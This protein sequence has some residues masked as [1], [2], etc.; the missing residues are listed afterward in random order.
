M[1]GGPLQA[2]QHLRVEYGQIAGHRGDLLEVTLAISCHLDHKASH[3][4]STEGNPDDRPH[5]DPIHEVGRDRIPE[6]I[7][8]GEGGDAR[9]DPGHG[10]NQ[11]PAA[12]LISSTL[13]KRSQLN[14]GRPKCP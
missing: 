11:R 5:F 9:D 8:D 13:S 1:G 3:F 2:V 4:A 10:S 7:V 14:P 6:P 12:A